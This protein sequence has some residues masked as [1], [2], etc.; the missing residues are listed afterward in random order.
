MLPFLGRRRWESVGDGAKFTPKPLSE[1]PL[2]SPA[3]PNL[4]KSNT[5]SAT[6]HRDG[7]PHF[8]AGIRR[9][10]DATPPSPAKVEVDHELDRPFRRWPQVEGIG[11]QVLDDA[12]RRE[13]GDLPFVQHCSTPSP[14]LESTFLHDTGFDPSGLCLTAHRLI[15]SP[16]GRRPRPLAFTQYGDRP[17]SE[18]D[19]PPSLGG[20]WP[21]GVGIGVSG[22]L[23]YCA[24]ASVCCCRTLSLNQS[25]PR[26]SAKAPN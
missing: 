26:T 9:Q 5:G 25:G 2:G 22:Y 7:R 18:T 12:A 14:A 21:T 17:G 24:R 19:S 4:L 11:P 3:F 10:N 20:T 8:K 15:P 6:K 23:A 13:Q 1:L 16:H